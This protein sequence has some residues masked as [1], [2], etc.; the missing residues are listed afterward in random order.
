MSAAGLSLVTP[1]LHA[2]TGL[3]DEMIP[4]T[5]LHDHGN[6]R[7]DTYALI[8]GFMMILFIEMAL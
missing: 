3:D 6:I 5:H 8:L 7:L 1:H 4:E 2:I